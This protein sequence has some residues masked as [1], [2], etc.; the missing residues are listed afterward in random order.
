LILYAGRDDN[1]STAAAIQQEAPWLSRYVVEL[2]T[3][4]AHTH[5][6]LADEPYRSLLH[7]ARAGRILAV[8]GGPNCRT[9]SIRLHIPKTGGGKPLRGRSDETVWG[10]D[11]N[12]GLD[13]SKTDDDSTLLLRQLNIYHQ[14]C[15]GSN[16]PVACLFEY[17][18]DPADCNSMPAAQVCSSIWVTTL[19]KAFMAFHALLMIMFDQCRFGQIVAKTTTVMI[20]K[21]IYDAGLQRLEAQRCNHDSRHKEVK[22]TDSSS[23]SR[24]AWG[25]N[26]LLAR[27]L[28]KHTSLALLNKQS[29][30]IALKPTGIPIAQAAA[31]GA[32]TLLTGTQYNTHS[33]TQGMAKGGKGAPLSRTISQQSECH[34]HAGRSCL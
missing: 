10:L 6:M 17:P 14:A 9:W 4:R 27:A 24:W 15:C 25:F 32:E 22:I 12:S 3:L 21:V 18:S 29:D 33:S 7:A 19:L 5:D 28:S 20:D 31:P 16:K 1:T 2:D 8:L 23:L 13:Q 11:T 26:I 30:T 34:C